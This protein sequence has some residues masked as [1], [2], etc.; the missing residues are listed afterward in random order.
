MRPAAAAPPALAIAV[1]AS[2]CGGALDPKGEGSERIA[3]LFWVMFWALAAGYVVLLVVLVLALARSR[4]R[5]NGRRRV[6]DRG[7]ILLGGVLLPLLVLLPVIAMTISTGRSVASAGGDA[8][9]IEVTGR[10]FWWDLRYPAPGSLSLDDEGSFRTANEIHIPVGRPVELRLIAPDVIHSFWIPQLHGKIDLVPGRT[11]TFRIEANEP[12][13]YR[14]QCAEFCGLGHAYMR[15]L[16]VAH[17]QEEF[18]AWW[19]HEAAPASVDADIGVLQQYANSCAPCHT[20]RG[21]YDSPTFQGD[22]GPDLTH[23]ASRR[24]IA[25]NLIPNTREALGRWIVDPKGS[26]PGTLMPDVGVGGRDLDALVDFL[27]RLE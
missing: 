20:L 11:N 6:S 7:V 26:K 18:E 12:G 5:S 8:L 15:L 1:L 24:M 9:Q 27:E 23:L 14:G 22:F 13:V 2:G 19:R 25:A 17:R 16:V 21:V 4:R 10:Q 3:D